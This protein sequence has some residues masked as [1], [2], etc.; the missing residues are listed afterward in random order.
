MEIG[1]NPA[2]AVVETVTAIGIE[3]EPLTIAELGDT[4]HIELAGDRSK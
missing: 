3:V 2:M 1:T 4:V